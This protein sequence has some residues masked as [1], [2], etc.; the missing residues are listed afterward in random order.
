MRILVTGA[1]GFVGRAIVAELL[2]EN[3]EVFCMGSLSRAG[4]D[5]LPNFLRADITNTESLE[6]LE[7]LPLIDV[8]IHTAG[9][10]HQFGGASLEEF[11]RINVE[12]TKNVC[13]LAERLGVKHFIHISSVSVYGRGKQSG[14]GLLAEDVRCE[15]ESVYAQS[16][17]EAEKT[18]AD[19]CRKNSILL[20]ILR[21]A[22]IIGENDPGNT[23]RLIEAIDN[24]KFIWIG[25]GENYKSLIYKTDVAR[26]CLSVLKK[27]SEKAESSESSESS[28]IFNL[29]AEPVSMKEIVSEIE[30]RLD[31]KVPK[32][33]IPGRLLRFVLKTNEKTFRIEKVRKL[34]ETVEKWLADDTF[35]GEKIAQACGFRAAT[36]VRAALQREVDSYLVQKSPKGRKG[37]KRQSSQ[38]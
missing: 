22:T 25:K 15:P 30:K 28:E 11:W 10:A 26:A 27:S 8:L 16:K 34:S 35:S 9:L 32:I 18:A 13:L 21:P 14:G 24:R 19:I 2:M 31:K 20:T 33:R 23:W 7:S 29:T 12:G 5:E 36:P 4:T 3:L 37:L 17:F 38:K 6:R 1:T